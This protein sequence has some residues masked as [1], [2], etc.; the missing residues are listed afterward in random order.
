ML[1]DGCTVLLPVLAPVEHGSCFL[2]GVDIRR[3]VTW[4]TDAVASILLP[5]VQMMHWPALCTP[6]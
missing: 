6:I 3:V 5:A 2:A 4:K 1:Q